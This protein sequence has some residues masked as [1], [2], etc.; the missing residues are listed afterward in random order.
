MYK[1]ENAGKRRPFFHYCCRPGERRGE[2]SRTEPNGAGPGGGGLRGQPGPHGGQRG[3]ERGAGPREVRFWGGSSFLARKSSR[4][5]AG[6]FKASFGCGTRRNGGDTAFRSRRVEMGPREAKSGR[7]KAKRGIKKGGEEGVSGRGAALRPLGPPGTAELRATDGGRREQR[8]E[9]P[10]GKRGKS[11]EKRGKKIP[12]QKKQGKQRGKKRRAEPA[13]GAAPGEERCGT[14]R[15]AAPGGAEPPASV[16]P[17]P[18]KAKRRAPP[19]GCDPQLRVPEPSAPPPAGLRDGGGLRPPN[20]ASQRCRGR[21]RSACGTG[22]G[23]DPRIRGLSA[24]GTAQIRALR[25]RVPRR[26][27]GAALRLRGQR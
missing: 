24:V 16:K 19:P 15:S 12:Q 7:K 20:S 22:V 17:P 21:P 25:R 6:H 11:G 2:R 8:G 10:R 4:G 27:V 23:S 14:E 1:K 18:E 3:A 9:F 13:V 26:W 5:E